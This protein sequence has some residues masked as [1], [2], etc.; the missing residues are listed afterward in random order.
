[1]GSFGHAAPWEETGPDKSVNFLL[2][3]KRLYSLGV[4]SHAKSSAAETWSYLEA[5]SFS[6]EGSSAQQNMQR[7]HRFTVLPR[8]NHLWRRPCHCFPQWAE[9]TANEMVL[10][11]LENSWRRVLV[12]D[13]WRLLTLRSRLLEWRCRVPRPSLGSQGSQHL[14]VTRKVKWIECQGV[15]CQRASSVLDIKECFTMSAL[16]LIIIIITT[17]L[18]ASVSVTI[19]IILHELN[20]GASIA[21]I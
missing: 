5:L 19:L 15:T 14:F 3:K 6:L 7:E 16:Y 10:I 18:T 2:V 8:D 12:L 17:L 11:P 20:H 13:A 21:V 1:M 4:A 9:R